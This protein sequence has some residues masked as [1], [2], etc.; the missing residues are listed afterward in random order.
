MRETGRAECPLCNH[1]RS[2]GGQDGQGCAGN[3]R[4]EA[5]H[6]LEQRRQQLR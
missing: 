4:P 1:G 2:V 6:D 3:G 5:S